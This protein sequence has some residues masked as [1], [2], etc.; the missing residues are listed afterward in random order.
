MKFTKPMAMP[1]RPNIIHPVRQS[2]LEMIMGISAP[3]VI[4]PIV[5]PASTMARLNPRLLSLVH[6]WVTAIT[7]AQQAAQPIPAIVKKMLACKME[8]EYCIKKAPMPIIAT[9]I[10]RIIRISYLSDSNPIKGERRV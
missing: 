9:K 3:A 10:E 1:K 2:E 8:V 6:L 5:L 4:T 7:G